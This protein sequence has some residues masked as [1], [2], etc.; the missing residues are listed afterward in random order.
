MAMAMPVS[1]EMA[2]SPHYIDHSQLRAFGLATPEPAQLHSSAAACEVVGASG[3]LAHIGETLRAAAQHRPTS[4]GTTAA[5]VQKVTAVAVECSILRPPPGLFP[6][7][8]LMCEG[9]AACS[10]ASHCAFSSNSRPCSPG[11]TATPELLSD[12]ESASSCSAES[13]EEIQESVRSHVGPPPGIFHTA[14][15]GR[16]VQRQGPPGVF[17]IAA[18]ATAAPPP[19]NFFKPS[20]TR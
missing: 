14:A 13:S 10:A 6:P 8:G 3:S 4:V 1:L 19:G 17:Q 18:K 12:I 16:P 5:A 15:V 20:L 11:P 9:K 2:N 7:P